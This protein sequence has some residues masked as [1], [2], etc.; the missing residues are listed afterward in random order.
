MSGGCI[1]CAA[2]ASCTELP[3]H[4][5]HHAL[6]SAWCVYQVKTSAVASVLSKV[7]NQSSR[8]ECPQECITMI[9]RESSMDTFAYP[10]IPP[11]VHPY[12]EGHLDFVS[13]LAT[14]IA[15]LVDIDMPIV[16]LL[17]KSP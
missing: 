8:T 16:D 7:G 12:P 10:L 14:P 5:L 6:S 9:T 15:H 3:P 1:L 17:I 2:D 13:T 11:L 4:Q